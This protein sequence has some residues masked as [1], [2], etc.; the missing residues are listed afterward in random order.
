MSSACTKEI[1]STKV[2]QS[3]E[4]TRQIGLKIF[5]AYSS[6]FVDARLWANTQGQAAFTA[7]IP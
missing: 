6:L 7:V 4:I 1:A 5:M 2:P 3:T